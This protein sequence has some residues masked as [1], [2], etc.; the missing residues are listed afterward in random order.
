M[1]TMDL[2]RLTSQHRDEFAISSAESRLRIWSAI[3]S[4]APLVQPLCN[5]FREVLS[6]LFFLGENR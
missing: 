6:P 2:H 1:P 5:S 3:D 4:G